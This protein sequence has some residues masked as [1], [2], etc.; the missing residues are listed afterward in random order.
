MWQKAGDDIAHH[1]ARDQG[2]GLGEDGA[3]VR[4]VALRRQ[5]AG[6]RGIGPVGEGMAGQALVI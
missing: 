2:I 5:P 3:I 6:G 1:G 4:D